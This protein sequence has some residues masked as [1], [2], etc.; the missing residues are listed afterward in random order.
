[1]NRKNMYASSFNAY[2]NYTHLITGLKPEIDPGPESLIPAL[3]ESGIYPQVHQEEY[4][5][6]VVTK[7]QIMGCCRGMEVIEHHCLLP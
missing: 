5:T 3:L 7:L 4:L 6:Q 1:M 2:K